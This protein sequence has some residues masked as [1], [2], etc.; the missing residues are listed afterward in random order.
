MITVCFE[1]DYI[2]AV[3]K[4]NNVLVHHSSMSRNKSEELSLVQLLFNQFRVKYYPL[5]RLDRKT[6]G[7]ILFVKKKQ[8]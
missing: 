7:V 5:H 1:D 3:N 4:P 6:S 8:I 2:L